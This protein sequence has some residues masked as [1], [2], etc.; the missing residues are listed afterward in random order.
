M[1]VRHSSEQIFL[2]GLR[3]RGNQSRGDQSADQKIARG[4]REFG[5]QLP[6]GHGTETPCMT[7]SW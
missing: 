5:R 2:D 3:R 4:R 1:Q 6:A 7:A